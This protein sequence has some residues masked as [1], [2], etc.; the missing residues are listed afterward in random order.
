MKEWRG[1][2]PRPG[3]ASLGV[4]QYRPW[5]TLAG[6]QHRVTTQLLLFLKRRRKLGV[7]LTS[8]TPMFLEAEAGGL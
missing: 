4:G 1:A 6:E 5:D 3:L 7:V 8:A 2:W